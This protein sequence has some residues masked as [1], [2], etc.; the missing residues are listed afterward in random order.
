MRRKRSL[1]SR[2]RSLLRACARSD[3]RPARRAAMSKNLNPTSVGVDGVLAQ[4]VEPCREAGRS[5]IR[6]SGVDRTAR[7]CR[8]TRSFVS[9]VL[10]TLT[11][12]STLSARAARGASSLSALLEVSGSNPYCCDNAAELRMVTCRGREE[13]QR[14]AHSG[15]ETLTLPPSHAINFMGLREN[16]LAERTG[17]SLEISRVLIQLEGSWRLRLPGQLVAR[18]RPQR[19]PRPAWPS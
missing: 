10:A 2:A 1:P 5:A 8:S 15:S 9:C 13:L 16:L 14:R 4:P 12:M 17:V 6:G 3:S 18:L 7:D 19:A 11:L